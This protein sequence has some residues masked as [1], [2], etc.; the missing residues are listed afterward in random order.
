[1]SE[2]IKKSEG[3]EISVHPFQTLQPD[4]RPVSEGSDRNKVLGTEVAI[5]KERTGD[6]IQSTSGRESKKNQQ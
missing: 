5:I 6:L 4:T 3:V 2:T 1:M